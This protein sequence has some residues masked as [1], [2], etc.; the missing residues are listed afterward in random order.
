MTDS[1][2]RLEMQAVTELRLKLLANGYTPLPNYDKRNFL[3]GWP[4]VKVDEAA[5]TS[6]ARKHKSFAATGLRL[7]DGLAVIDIDIDDEVV[8]LLPDPDLP[9]DILHRYGGGWKEARFLCTS[10]PFGRIHSRR[11]V[12][13]GDPLDGPA[14]GI[15]IFGGASARQF[16]AFGAHTR[17]D[18]GETPVVYEWET[19]ESPDIIPLKS[20]ATLTKQEFFM[21]IDAAEAR[22]KAEGWQPVPRTK[23][24]E[25]A[26]TRV[27]DLTDDMLFEINTNANEILSLAELVEYAGL[28]TWAEAS[29]MRCSASFIESGAVNRTR[30]IVGQTHDGQLTVWDSATDVTHLKVEP[31]IEDMIAEIGVSFSAPVP[32]GAAPVDDSDDLKSAAVKLV[33][34]YAFCPTAATKNV[35]PIDTTDI[36]AGM[37]LAN[38]RIKYRP[39]GETVPAKTP[40]GNDT[41]KFRTPTDLWELSRDRLSVGGLRMRPDMPAP[42]YEEDGVTWVNTYRPVAHPAGGDASIG[43]EFM[44]QL[45]PDDTE[46]HWLMSW[47]ACKLSAPCEPGPGVIMVAEE[48][49]TGRATFADLLGRLFGR[50]YVKAIKFGMLTGQVGQSQY[51]DWSADALIVVVNESSEDP[52][53]AGSFRTKLNAYEHLKELVDPRQ[54]EHLIVRKGEPNYMAPRYTSYI[55]ATNHRDALVLPADD[56]RLAVLTNGSQ[57]PPEYWRALNAW[58][59]D[60]ANIGAFARYLEAYDVGEYTPHR[61]VPSFK[62][63]NAM[64]YLSVSDIDQAVADAIDGMKS[65]LTTLDA[66][67]SSAQVHLAQGDYASPGNGAALRRTARRRLYRLQ[68]PDIKDERVRMP[69]GR[70]HHA[71]AATEKIAD[72]WSTAS[73]NNIIEELKKGLSDIGRAASKS[74]VVAFPKNGEEDTGEKGE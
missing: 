72:K 52:V 63:K 36:G 74:T 31:T 29:D 19:D 59:D 1:A 62:A 57:R 7:Q 70:N 8:T 47:L 45:V 42:T 64:A 68:R 71:C 37:A 54:S 25:N 2:Q 50:R 22:L 17:L 44:T 69:D 20:L 15:E 11:W 24:G 35:V 34:L 21:F 46:R 13:P 40:Q 10:E 12:R 61:H 65:E 32:P 39:W 67:V 41:T 55:I 73:T 33:G 26:A 49:G 56:R 43:I 14:Y 51:N 6:W 9:I 5:I 28:R 23:A 30:C 58:M 3:K 38:M 66:I 16:G 60:P 27:Y 4:T 18:N 48:Y 53:G